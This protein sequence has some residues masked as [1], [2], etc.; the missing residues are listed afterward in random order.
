MPRWL[1]SGVDPKELFEAAKVMLSDLI[2]SLY[3]IREEMPFDLGLGEKT[4]RGDPST[5]GPG[6]K[7]KKGCLN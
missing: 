5:R 2:R 1:K 6:Q 4:G 3:G 7:Y